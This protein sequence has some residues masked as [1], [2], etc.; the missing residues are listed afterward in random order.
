MEKEQRDVWNSLFIG[1]K[2]ITRNYTAIKNGSGLA[3][4][5]PFY[6]DGNRNYS[7]TSLVNRIVVF[8]VSYSNYKR[9]MDITGAL[10]GLFLTLPIT[11]ILAIL[12]KITS[13]GPIFFFQER[14]GQYGKSF[15]LCKFRSMIHKA[16][17]SGPQLSSRK[18]ERV[19]GI[20]KI[21]RR[22]KLDEIPNFLNVLTGEMSL[23]GYRPER[24]FYI[25]LMGKF[26]DQYSKLLKIKPG[27]TSLGQIKHGYAF[28]VEEMIF[29]LQFDLHYLHTISFLQDC[30]ILIHTVGIIIFGNQSRNQVPNL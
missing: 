4:P 6:I 30:K 27:I 25:G 7:F 18:D 1:Y 28:T 16:E 24:L 22:Y 29:R 3:R 9:L 23:V 20:G 10:I 14:V 26:T 5:I 15:Y 13:K 21:M 12:I 11:C 17:L 2:D 19:T 8:C